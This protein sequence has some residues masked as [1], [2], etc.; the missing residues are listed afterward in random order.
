MQIATSS[1]QPA[2]PAAERG[3]ALLRRGARQLLGSQREEQARQQQR[4]DRA[5]ADQAAAALR[6]PREALE[7]HDGRAGEEQRHGVDPERDRDDQGQRHAAARG[8]QHIPEKRG[9]ER[10]VTPRPRLAGTHVREGDHLAQ[11][12]RVREHHHEPVDADAEPAGRRQPDLERAQVVLVQRMRLLVAGRAIA[13]RRQQALALIV[14]IVELA[15]GVADLHA[16]HEGLE[17]LHQA[18]VGGLAL[19]QRRELDRVV[20]DE[21]RAGSASARRAREKSVVHEPA[22]GGRVAVGEIPAR[23]RGLAQRRRGR[24]RP[25]RRSPVARSDR[26]AQRHARPRSPPARS[27]A[28]GSSMRVPPSTLRAI[29]CSIDSASSIMSP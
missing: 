6:G 5:E 11:A 13:A 4:P 16:G 12:R 1:A 15:E 25:A 8:G 10:H 23:A 9:G 20:G 7:R 14:R 24:R 18:R 21:A 29:S 3:E 27:R 28:P 2:S 17:A 26:V 19:R 22:P